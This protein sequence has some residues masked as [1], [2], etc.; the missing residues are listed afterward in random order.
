[1]NDVQHPN[2][3]IIWPQDPLSTYDIIKLSDLVLISWTTVG[4]EA[5]RSGIPTIAINENAGAYGRGGIIEIPRSPQEYFDSIEAALHQPVSNH[6]LL[7][8]WR[9]Y[10]FY[11]LKSALTLSIKDLQ[12]SEPIAIAT[13]QSLNELLEYQAPITRSTFLQT[14]R[15]NARV[16]L[17]ISN[18]LKSLRQEYIRFAIFLCINKS[19][20]HIEAIDTLISDTVQETVKVTHPTLIVDPGGLKFIYGENQWEVSYP[21]ARKISRIVFRLND[22][23][24]RKE[25]SPSTTTV[26]QAQSR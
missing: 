6:S 12:S 20:D 15:R 26:S 7:Q 2:L 24:T 18:E 5:A 22:E 1:M 16:R 23:I 14:I 21:L 10:H 13:L 3:V 9:W 19:L 17:S 11:H 4:H 8:T 25:Y